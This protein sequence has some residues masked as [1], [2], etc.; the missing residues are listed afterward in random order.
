MS[1]VPNVVS[2]SGFVFSL[3][4]LRYSLTFIYYSVLCLVYRMLS[5][6]LDC[7]FFIA[8]LVFSSV[9]YTSLFCVLCTECCQCLWIFLSLLHLRYSSSNVAFTSLFC[10]LCT[11]C[12]Q[13]LWIFFSLLHLRYS[14][15]NVYLLV[16][17]VSCV[18]NV[19]SVSGLSFLYCI[20]G[21]LALTFIY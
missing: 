13:C 16:C 17:S 12:C 10:V 11:E 14:S 15:S 3:L 8:S 20:F 19:V 1:C 5:V 7:L 4:H 18:P 6:S 21:I 9:Y 2:V